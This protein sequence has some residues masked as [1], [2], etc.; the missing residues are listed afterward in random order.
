MA[1]AGW[2]LYEQESFLTRILSLTL[3]LMRNSMG[4]LPLNLPVLVAKVSR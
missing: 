4:F 1:V 3:N 2:I